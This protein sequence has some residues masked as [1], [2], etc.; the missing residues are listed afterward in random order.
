MLYKE[1]KRNLIPLLNCMAYDN[2]NVQTVKIINTTD[3]QCDVTCPSDNL[4]IF[5]MQ[6]CIGKEILFK[7]KWMAP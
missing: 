7:T 2:L 5:W 4:F 6:S 3:I 1:I